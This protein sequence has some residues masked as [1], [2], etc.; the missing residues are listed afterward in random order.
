MIADLAPV[1]VRA[2]QYRD[3]IQR[4]IE[5]LSP[6]K[7]ALDKSRK[8]HSSDDPIF[9]T[10]RVTAEVTAILAPRLSEIETLYERINT[11]VL[12]GHG[13]EPWTRA[14]Y[15][16]HLKRIGLYRGQVDGLPGKRTEEAVAA[17]QRMKNM[18]IVDG[19][20]GPATT[21]LLIADGA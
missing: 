5:L 6:V 2:F 9:G 19:E 15:Q 1:A 10:I 11:R 12:Q 13:S 8:E 14:R 3:D 17:F 21:E 18:T 4:L 16:A 20:V 7:D